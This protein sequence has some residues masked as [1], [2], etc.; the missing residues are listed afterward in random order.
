MKRTLFLSYLIF[1]SI[2]SFA[3]TTQFENTNKLFRTVNKPIYNQHG[4][5]VSSVETVEPFTDAI[6][7]TGLKKKVKSTEIVSVNIT[8]GGLYSSFNSA[9][10]KTITA[11][12]ITGT[13]DARDFK[14]M[15]DSMTL[16]SDVDFSEAS[17]MQY[18]GNKG[19]NDTITTLY[20]TNEIPTY[21]F[22]SKSY[23]NG[24]RKLQY[25]KMSSSTIS[26]GNYAFQYC[27]VLSSM[28]IASSVV[29]IGNSAFYN[30]SGFTSFY[31]PASVTHIGNSAFLGINCTINVDLENT[32]FS[33]SNGILFNKDQS[34]LIK[35]P[36]NYGGSYTIPNTVDSISNL[37]F[38]ACRSL[39]DVTIPNS[40]KFL[41]NQAFSYC[42]VLTSMFVPSSVLSMGSYV[43][44]GSS[45][46]INVDYTNPNFSS[47]EGVLFDKLKIKL[48]QC[49]TSKTGL[50]DIPISVNS[51]GYM[52]FQN[53]SSL[54]SVTIPS[55]ITIIPSSIFNNCT[56]L[57]LM[58]IPAS[59]TTIGG[60]AFYNCSA[61][62]TLY[63]LP[64][65]PIILSSTSNVFYNVNKST[66]TLYVPVGSKSSYQ[67][68]TLWKDFQNIVE[69]STTPGQVSDTVNILTAGT[70]A[71]LISAGDRVTLTN[72][73][74]SGSI[75]ASD[76]RSMRD[77]I[78]N[79]TDLDL[80][81][82]TIVAYSGTQGTDPTLGTANGTYLANAIPQHAFDI[83]S[84]YVGNEKLK[85]V[86][87]PL[88][89]TA[90]CT[91]AFVSCRALVSISVPNT[92]NSIE[93]FA[94]DNCRAL[95]SFKIPDAIT[96]ITDHAFSDTGLKHLIIP[97]SVT[98]INFQSFWSC[99]SLTML[100][101]PNSLS[102]IASMAF[103]SCGKL[104]SVYVCNSTP[105]ALSYSPFDQSDIAHCTLYVPY[106]AKSK[107]AADK[108]WN[109]F[110][111]IKEDSLG[112]NLSSNSVSISSESGSKATVT[113]L[114]NIDWAVSVDQ[115]WLNVSPTTGSN[116]NNII[117]TAD[118]NT[119][120]PTRSAIV[121]ISAK[122]K[123]SQTIIVTQ[124]GF[125]KTINNI[126]GSLKS[127]LSKNEKATITNLRIT[128]T[129]DARDFYCLRD[130]MPNL[131]LLDLK[132]ASV[133]ADPESI[134][135]KNGVPNNA[136]Y[137][138]NTG[139]AI[140]KLK[141][142]ILPSSVTTIGQYSF[143][144]C[145]TLQSVVLPNSLTSISNFAFSNCSQLKEVMLPESLINIGVEAF[146][147]CQSLKEVL[148]PNSVTSIG[149]RVFYNCS[150]LSHVIYPKNLKTISRSCFEYCSALDIFTIPNSVEFIDMSAFAYCKGLT[151][152]TM[153]NSVTYINHRAFEHCDRLKSVTIPNSVTYLGS[154]AF[155]FCDSIESITI[156]NSVTS[157]G[158]SVFEMCRNLKSIYNYCTTPLIIYPSSPVFSFVSK[159]DCILY[160]P[161]GTKSAYQAAV[162]W[163]DFQNIIE[164]TT[165][166]PYI[167][168]SKINL[169]PNPVT[170]SFQINGNEGAYKVTL[171]DL[172]GK[173]KFSKQ[174]VGNEKIPVGTLSNGV[175]IAKIIT[176]EG[177]F[178]RKIV[179]E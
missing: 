101:L 158:N 119:M 8:A 88:S 1:L 138:S 19:T 99:D 84:P 63:A 141:T 173:T 118:A 145:M 82:A 81:D 2:I 140:P 37:A 39:T 38:F 93:N 136:F 6:S 16:L 79:L 131:L 129:I 51:L 57:T 47:A 168:D 134:G 150:S 112:F 75:D 29:S 127:T 53:C 154:Y 26:I 113:I 90:I 104:D 149:D 132:D 61:L 110:S 15:R 143:F 139:Y 33:D 159:T 171:Y 108:V 157:T 162:E 35:Y 77:L 73:T 121:T 66:C 10:L 160:V 175:Y 124:D 44:M 174:V 123:A 78:P 106:K 166:V 96:S 148:I 60:S 89:T 130:S 69:V 114:S 71:S 21:A 167:L 115:S 100:S 5:I 54:T 169:Y 105:P 111:T 170:S 14:T 9:V 163:K 125:L 92:I 48:I 59:V 27:L 25:L 13:I 122:D 94:F 116:D 152:L 107:Y 147:S 55:S 20:P 70:L 58:T 177:T 117:I 18:Y 22:G 31:I 64:S 4:D 40:V 49:P 76:F 120:L 28:N 43:F 83:G 151:S 133:L 80:T 72:L 146:L 67:S 98:S 42:N 102:Y 179:K 52:A 153:P 91:K 164:M 156:P 178:E 103:G 85:N 23:T 45:C 95:E 50:Y 165:A 97:N 65:N 137:N 34:T 41:G 86:K 109:K 172:N 176:S 24:N 87:L 7:Y 74:V 68:A 12:K 30:C 144:Y 135:T 128:G 11:L 46:L 62:S 161:S 126:A 56:G 36:S 17:I 142:I 32:A 3:Q 155:Y